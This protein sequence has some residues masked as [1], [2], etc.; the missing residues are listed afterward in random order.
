MKH[1]VGFIGTG[2]I[3]EIHARSI[4][5]MGLGWRIA[6]GYDMD[7]ERAG[8]FCGKYGGE[9]YTSAEE[10]VQ[11][12]GIDT[13]YVCTRHDS[14]ADYGVM[15]CSYGKNVF[16]E[17][18]VAMDLESAMRLREFQVRHPVRF[19]VGYNMRVAPAI[20]SLK[21]KLKEYHVVPDTFR[22][23][24]TGT[25]FMQGWAGRPDIGGGVL[26][27]QGSHMFDLIADVMGSPIN[28]VCV[29]T[30]WIRQSEELEPNCAAVLVRLENGVCGTLLM[31]DQ[32][33]RSYHVE[34]GG[35]M[36]N[37]TVYSRQGT[38]DADAYGRMR[39]GIEDGLFE[40]LPPDPS[41]QINRW[42]YQNEAGYF[43]EQL[44]TGD[45]PLCTLDQAVHT[46][47]VVEAARRSAKRRSWI[48]VKR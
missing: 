42:G 31:H 48:A 18:P 20:L 6:G 30:Q 2:E 35:G 44:E 5:G 26:V 7:Q 28:E 32:G 3:A 46:A 34:P 39:Y 1:A 9:R 38:F 33:N 47:A 40:E 41:A 23:N 43:A 16:M 4:L 10:M 45:S 8:Y 36:V 15:A 27:C 21:K 19:A 11:S 37:I 24:M 22:V 17:K 12:P 25:P 29:E 14:H 13:I